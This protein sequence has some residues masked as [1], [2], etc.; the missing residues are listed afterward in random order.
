MVST[1]MVKQSDRYEWLSAYLKSRGLQTIW[2]GAM[3]GLT[4]SLAAL[5]LVLLRSP[6]GPD[7]LMSRAV[8]VIASAVGTAAAF[9]WLLRWPTR[10]QSFLYSLAST[11]IITAWCLTLSNPYS[12]FLGLPIFAMLGGFIAYF[13]NAGYTL[14]NF[15]VFVVCEG[16]LS[17]RL[18]TTTGDIALTAASALIMTALNIG[19][20]IGIHLIVRS[21]RD[22]LHASEHDPLT[23]LHNRRSFY[24]SAYELMLRNHSPGTHLVIV[25]IDLDDFKRVNDTQGH[26]VGD[27]ALVAVAA[28]LQ[29][30]CRPTAVIGRSGGEEFVIADTDTASNP[31]MMAD[32]LR[33]AIAGVRFG[34]TASIGT[35]GISLGP[36]A[37]TDVH[38][39]DD[40]IRASDTAMY[41]AKRAGGNQV[42]HHTKLVPTGHE[43][44]VDR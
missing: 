25:V 39:I 14:A 3:V 12:G 33:Q 32:R 44:A 1:P 24:D 30:N 7:H 18:I 16:I 38:L 21:L 23:G 35:C 27:Q 6:A 17:F 36:S 28:A 9:L 15:G 22:D 10:R 5:P 42:C 2:R 20:P 13:H 34:I 4:A 40:L 26:A 29:E 43:T 19:V 31:G 8:S 11:V 37:T 41:E